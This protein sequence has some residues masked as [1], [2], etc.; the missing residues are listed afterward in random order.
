MYNKKKQI[1]I[2]IYIYTDRYVSHMAFDSE[3]DEV[4]VGFIH[5]DIHIYTYSLVCIGTL[6]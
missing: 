1:Y 3:C 4:P 2:Y 5:A 6:I